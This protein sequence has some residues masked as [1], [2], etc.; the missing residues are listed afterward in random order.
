MNHMA[1]TDCSAQPLDLSAFAAAHGRLPRLGD[2][3]PPWRY[4]GW[5]L[6]YVIQLHA[7]IPTVANRWGYLL[8]TLEAGRLLAEPI[9]PTAFGPPDS[10]VFTL[11]RDW[12]RLV[13]QDCGGWSDFHTLLEW[14]CWG[15]A[16][17]AEEP[18]LGDERCWR[19]WRAT[20]R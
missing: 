1:P 3:L 6:P 14:L 8:R 17:S 4:R 5:L 15:L 9:P 2:A 13:G 19:P 12:S 7:L 10:H 11:L 18:R 20:C 16:L